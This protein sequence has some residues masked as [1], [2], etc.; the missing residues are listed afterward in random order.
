MLTLPVSTLPAP[1]DRLLSKDGLTVRL[2]PILAR[3][4]EGAIYPLLDEPGFVAKLYPPAKA[5]ERE[6]R[7]QSMLRYPQFAR[8]RRYAWPVDLLYAFS[9]GRREFRGFIMPRLVGTPLTSLVIPSLLIARI[10]AAQHGPTLR[11]FL[12]RVLHS[13]ALGLEELE[14]AQVLAGDISA[15][16]FLV[17]PN[18]GAVSFLDCDSY[19]L[20][21]APHARFPATA[22]TPGYLPPELLAPHVQETPR[23]NEHV[24]FSAAVLFFELLTHGWH[25]YQCI[26]A[27]TPVENI[28]AG[29]TAMGSSHGLA[30][31]YYPKSIYQLYRAIHPALKQQ[32]IQTLVRGHHAPDKRADFR[33]WLRAI[34][35]AITAAARV[36]PVPTRHGTTKG[37]L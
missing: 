30:T 33:A 8:S 7:I 6:R 17:E 23:T 14:Q 10:P 1:P 13:L 26:G 15:A 27:Q 29:R 20:W 21:Q 3:G 18:T 2:G 35:T 37:K 19:Q 11:A 5:A 9:A 24:R 28:L 34:H 25:P 16:N 12:L 31:G 4:G 32:L 22:S 36:H